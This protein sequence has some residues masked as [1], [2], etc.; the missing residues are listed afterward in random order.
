MGDSVLE[1]VGSARCTWLNQDRLADYPSR[2][3][4]CQTEQDPADIFIAPMPHRPVNSGPAE[5]EPRP[6]QH[7]L[8]SAVLVVAD[9][10][11]VAQASHCKPNQGDCYQL[12]P[13]SRHSSCVRQ[14]A[15]PGNN[16]FWYTRRFSESFYETIGNTS[17]KTFAM[18]TKT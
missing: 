4:G 15:R 14:Q 6:D 1:V 16:R 8:A 12:L 17:A 2:I 5:P 3:L 7:L 11:C 9:P 10:C 18:A 13:S